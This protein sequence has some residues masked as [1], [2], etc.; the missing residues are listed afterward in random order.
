MADGDNVTWGELRDYCAEKQQNCHRL[1]EEESKSGALR[2]ESERRVGMEQVLR[3]VAE[4]GIRVG[5][6]ETRLSSKAVFVLPRPIL[7][8]IC[9][10]M[11]AAGVAFE[12]VG[13]AVL[14]VVTP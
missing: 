5:G 13:K 8:L 2:I 9:A 3:A 4:L 1:R 11:I 7:Y 6:I 10:G 14:G 12:K